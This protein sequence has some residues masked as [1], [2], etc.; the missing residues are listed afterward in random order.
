MRGAGVQSGEVIREIASQIGRRINENAAL[1]GT[2]RCP[3][4]ST[5]ISAKEEQL[6]P[7]DGSADGAAEDVL[8]EGADLRGQ[9]TRSGGIDLLEKIICVEE[10]IAIVL[11]DVAMKTIRALLDGGTDDAA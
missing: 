8:V 7:E 2:F 11:E 5:L 10:G 1:A 6:V 3:L 9:Q 4:T